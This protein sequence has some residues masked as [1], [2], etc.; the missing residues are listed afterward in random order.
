[1]NKNFRDPEWEKYLPRPVCEAHPEYNEFYTKAWELAHTHVRDIPGM[2]Q[3]PYM[4]EAFCDTQVWI[5][6]TCFMSLFCKFAQETFPGVETFNN[7]Y[8]VLYGGNPLPEI[9]PTEDEPWWTGATPG[10]PTNIKVHIADNPPLFAWAE[11]ENA[12]IHGDVEYIKELLYNSRALQRH[13]EWVDSLRSSVKLNGVLLP[14]HLENK[15]IGYTWEGGSSGMDNTPRGR[16]SIPSKERP[17]NP[18]MLWL[19]AICQQALSARMIAKLFAIVGD[20]DGEAE[21]NARFEEKKKI[22]NDLYWDDEDN[23]YYDIDSRDRHLYKVMTSASFWTMTA[24]VAPTER[25]RELVKRLGEPET[26]GGELPLLSLA[27]NDGDFKATGK[28]WRGSLWLPVAYAALK[29]LSTYGYHTEAHEAGYK[30]FKHML[31]TYREYEP[32]TIW[33]CYSPTAHRPATQTD[34]VTVVRPDFCGW[35]ALGPIS[36]YIENVLGFHTVNAFERLVEWEKPS[37]LGAEIGIRNLR[38]GNVVTDIVANK[39]KIS[40]SSNEPYM[41]KISGRAFEIK[42]GEQTFN[43]DF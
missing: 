6:D 20:T 19:D 9:V 42:A 7:F 39:N 25:A 13:Y 1:M 21:W 40:V 11:H 32:H 24:E 5:W 34:D 4:D 10:V 15:D 33:E 3:N 12:L 38:F 26:L 36:V 8:E 30:I 43:I 17:N 18:N 27:R 37:D 41:L 14:T 16:E 35:S 29:G 31:A 2:P 22:I 28:Y 23:F